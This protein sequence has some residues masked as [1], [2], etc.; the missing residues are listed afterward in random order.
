MVGEHRY[1]TPSLALPPIRLA[2][3]ARRS[4]GEKDLAWLMEYGGMRLFV[5]RAM[6]VQPSFRLTVQNADFGSG[7][8]S[9]SGWHSSGD[10]AGCGADALSF[11][12]GD[13]DSS[14]RPFCLSPGGSR[15]A[16][17]RH[18]TLRALIDWS[19]DLLTE[20]EK[21]LLRR[22]SVFAG[23]W[24]LEAAEFVCA[25]AERASTLCL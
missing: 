18:Q 21:R 3:S 13:P 5:E 23:G 14:A 6:Q 25:E 1:H 15:A 22:L 17:P 24:S 12:C 20:R 10:R 9:A 16:L 4:S 19:Y 7:R 2:R 11:H 8:G